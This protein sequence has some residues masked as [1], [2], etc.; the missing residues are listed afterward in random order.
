[1]AG[2]DAFLISSGN[3]GNTGI[4][5][6]GGYVVYLYREFLCPDDRAGKIDLE[7]ILDDINSLSILLLAV[8]Y[9]S[10]KHFHETDTL[11]RRHHV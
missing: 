5:G 1:M 6:P 10:Q 4:S 9:D 11:S 8:I 7:D 2:Q 3:R